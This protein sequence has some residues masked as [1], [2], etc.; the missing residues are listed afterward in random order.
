MESVGAKEGKREVHQS[1]I[2]MYTNCGMAYRLRYIDGLKRPPGVA[3]IT[4]TATHKSVEKNLGHKIKTGELLPLEAVEEIA[5]ASVNQVWDADGVLLSEEERDEGEAQLRGRTVDQAVALARLHHQEVAPHIQPLAVER[6]FKLVLPNHPVDVVGTIDVEEKDAIRDH[7]CYKKTPRQDD[8]DRSLQLTLYG[9]AKKVLDGGANPKRLYLDVMVKNK[10]PKVQVFQTMR[11]DE[12]YRC[13][14]DR[15][16]VVANA[17]AQGVFIP[18]TPDNWRCSPKWCG[19]F[20]V[21]EYGA[22][23]RVAA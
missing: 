16:D 19:Y 8:V 9:L 4:G 11:S 20:D 3:A 14:L 17:I 21:C 23:R 18:A 15:L 13:F 7:K 1:Q 5:A 12:D 22:R 2:V 6:T 10:E